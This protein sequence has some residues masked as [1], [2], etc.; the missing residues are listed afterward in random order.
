MRLLQLLFIG[1]LLTTT[2]GCGGSDDD[3]SPGNV[4]QAELVSVTELNDT[5]YTVTLRNTS[6]ETVAYGITVR[7]L[8]GSVQQSFDGGNFVQNVDAGTTVEIETISS[9]FS[10]SDYDC[11]Q[12]ILQIIP[13]VTAV[14][15]Q[16]GQ[17]GEDCY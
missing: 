6:S 13:S 15:C 9:G 17:I 5:D 1:L 14:V 12:I 11:A 4:C 2:V 3:D 16:E 8:N 7:Y 10:R